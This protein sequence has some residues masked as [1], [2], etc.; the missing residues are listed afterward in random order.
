M[1]GGL[2]NILFPMAYCL[3]LSIDNKTD[4]A[5][6]YNHSGYLHTEP[7]EYKNSFLKTIP[8]VNDI[9]S[10]KRIVEK[11]FSFSQNLIPLGK[12]V[13]LDGYFQSERYF[14]KN[15]NSVINL[16]KSDQESYKKARKTYSEVTSPGDKTLSLH[17]RRGNYLKLKKYHKV[18]NKSYYNKALSE[19][20]HTKVLVFSDD[21]DYC[22]SIFK[23]DKFK[24]IE[25][26]SDIHDLYLMSLCDN[27][28]IANS[29]FSWWGAYLNEKKDKTIIAP[30]T[31]FGP[32]N[33][34]INTAD[35]IPEEWIKI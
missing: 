14:K 30:K 1:K 19:I 20:K 9:S 34:H 23:S 6:Y 12:D 11:D 5:L 10:Y 21:I 15:K 17:V 33:S 18:L 32:K 26:G 29:T 27:H 31:W 2:G 24:I 22:K 16:I 4:L 28:I 7:S 13:F 8:E 25:Q 3:S 35:L